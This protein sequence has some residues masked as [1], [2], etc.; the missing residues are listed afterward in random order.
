MILNIQNCKISLKA[1]ATL[2]LIFCSSTNVQASSSPLDYL[3][4][5]EDKLISNTKDL[6]AHKLGELEKIIGRSYMYEEPTNRSIAHLLWAVSYFHYED[7]WAI[8]EFMKVNE[9]PIYKN[10][11]ADEFEWEKIRGATQEYLKSNKNQ[12]PTRFQFMMP[13]KLGDYDEKRKAFK[14]QDTHKIE[15]LRRFEVFTKDHTAM[16][17]SKMDRI[18]SGYPRAI[19]L[20]YSRPFNLTFV[21]TPEQLASDFIKLSRQN[22]KKNFGTRNMTKK[23]LYNVRNAYLVMKVKIFTHGKSTGTNASGLP[24]VQMMGVLEGYDVYADQQKEILLY[25]EAY[26][27]NK[28]KGRL[29][30]KLEEQYTILR[31]KTKGAGILT[32]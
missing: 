12:F 26:V 17:C 32:Y 11:A 13:I 27:T 28:N 10:F 21:P 18:K 2:G 25:S 30:A 9:C 6:S 15:S 24:S 29:N 7:T 8:D 5:Y 31:E 22:Y 1:I 16:P 19:I 20:E 14:V 3:N 4:G 23:S